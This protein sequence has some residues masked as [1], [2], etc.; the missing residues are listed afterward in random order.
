MPHSTN[1][2]AAF[3]IH[4]GLKQADA[5]SSF[6]FN[7]AL[8]YTIRKVQGNQE[9]TQLIGT[10]Q[11]LVYANDV[12]TLEEHKSSVQDYREDVLQVRAEKT[13]YESVSKSFRTES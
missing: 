10:H 6:L 8:K 13:K 1:L 12:N 4:N 11:L 5:L 2:S 9:G 7:I 3:P